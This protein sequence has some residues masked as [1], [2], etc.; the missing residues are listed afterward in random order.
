MLVL[1]DGE[2]REERWYGYTPIPFSSPKED[3]EAT[4][5]LLDR[6]QFQN[7]LWNSEVATPASLPE[8]PAATHPQTQEARLRCKCGGWVVTLLGARPA[9]GNAPG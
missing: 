6:R 3:E 4:H 8:L 9:S 1:E 7:P 2:C 5:E